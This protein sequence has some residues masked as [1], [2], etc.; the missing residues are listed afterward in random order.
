MRGI[1]FFV[2]FPLFL[3]G[4]L[5]NISHDRIHTIVALLFVIHHKAFKQKYNIYCN[6]TL[7]SK[8]KKN[9]LEW[10]QKMFLH[11]FKGAYNYTDASCI[12]YSASHDNIHAIKENVQKLL[13]EYNF[14][15][16]AQSLDF[17]IER[18]VATLDRMDFNHI[19]FPHQ[20]FVTEIE[21]SSPLDIM[22]HCLDAHASQDIIRLACEKKSLAVNDFIGRKY[23]GS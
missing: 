16:N 18:F 11:N 17:L 22:V 21:D 8:D 3:D 20:Q 19:F 14:S 1:L 13:L 5:K 6:D 7:K 23:T 15:F 9:R 4:F 12:L 10:L 2:L